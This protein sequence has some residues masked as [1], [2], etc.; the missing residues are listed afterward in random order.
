MIVTES[1]R[2]RPIFLLLF[3]T[4]SK[5]LARPGDEIWHHEKPGKEGNRIIHVSAFFIIDPF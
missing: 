4:S 5:A 1:K 3:N 2:V